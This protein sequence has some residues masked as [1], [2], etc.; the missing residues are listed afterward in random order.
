MKVT[1]WR[2]QTDVLVRNRPEAVMLHRR[3]MRLLCTRIPVIITKLAQRIRPVSA[4]L[5]GIAADHDLLTSALSFQ[6]GFVRLL[7]L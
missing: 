6:V 4:V 5:A 2:F 1:L 3:G 7:Q